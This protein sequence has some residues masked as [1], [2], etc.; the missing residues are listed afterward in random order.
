[1][2]KVCCL[3]SHWL[4]EYEYFPS[5]IVYTSILVSSVIFHAARSLFTSQSN[6]QSKGLNHLLTISTAWT[7]TKEEKEEEH[8][9]KEEEDAYVYVYICMMYIYVYVYVLCLFLCLLLCPCPCTCP[10]PCVYVCLCTRVCMC[11]CLR[12]I[13]GS[14]T[15]AKLSLYFLS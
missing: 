12:I 2:T 8:K 15:I 4:R 14:A 5:F 11:I 1:M 6:E 10:C 3:F 13:A 9:E 7:I